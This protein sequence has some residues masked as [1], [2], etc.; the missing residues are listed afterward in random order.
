MAE[1]SKTTTQADSKNKGGRPPKFKT[2]EELQAAIDAYFDDCDPHVEDEP[3]LVY[4]E[5]QDD[6]ESDLE[7][8]PHGGALKRV[9]RIDY[10]AEPSIGIRKRMSFQKP[11]TV[12]GLA[13]ALNTTRET[14]LDYQGKKKFSDT[15]KRAKLRIENYNE[16]QLYGK[17]VTGVIFNLKN[18]YGWQDRSQVEE[19]SHQTVTVITRAHDEDD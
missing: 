5:V 9:K 17:N 11:Y 2:V 7:E 15:I 19:E 8:Q 10:A 14:L 6:I 3:Y 1:Q 4:P 18:N 13:M 16:M 12:T